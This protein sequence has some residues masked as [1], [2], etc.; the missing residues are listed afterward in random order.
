M[1][2]P[3]EAAP[4]NPTSMELTMKANTPA[5]AACA[6]MAVPPAA[7]LIGVRAFNDMKDELGRIC[8]LV[9]AL[10]MAS[11]NLPRDERDAIQQVTS[12]TMKRIENLRAKLLNMVDEITTERGV[13]QQPPLLGDMSITELLNAE[14]AT[15]A[16]RHI[17]L[18]ESCSH[19][20][21]GDAD[22]LD[23]RRRWADYQFE[24]LDAELTAIVLELESR[25]PADDED[26]MDVLYGKAAAY[27]HLE[28]VNYDLQIVRSAQ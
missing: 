9:F 15:I 27:P 24:R 8:S 21:K 20:M 1:I 28:R 13:S 6:T 25:D 16:A 22:G 10:N 18:R 26:A 23:A 3:G 7:L 12:D 4:I 2:P 17:M 5:P 14:H 11:G 19:T